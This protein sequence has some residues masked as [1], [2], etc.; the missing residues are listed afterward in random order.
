MSR[1]VHVS[2]TRSGHS[3]SR[4]AAL[5]HGVGVVVPPGVPRSLRHLP[6]RISKIIPR[7]P[8]V[9]WLLLFG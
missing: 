4:Q 8:L 5:G 6:L 9:F 2:A 3:W 1:G 7:Y